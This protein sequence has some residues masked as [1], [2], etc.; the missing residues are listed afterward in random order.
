MGPLV[1]VLVADEL[2]AALPQVLVLGK[3]FDV[4]RRGSGQGDDRT[5]LGIPDGLLPHDAAAE[6]IRTGMIVLRVPPVGHVDPGVLPGVAVVVGILAAHE[7]VDESLADARGEVVED[8]DAAR[9]ADHG[10]AEVAVGPQSLG[11]RDGPGPGPGHPVVL[12]A[13]VHHPVVVSPF[14]GGQGPDGQQVSSGSDLDQHVVAGLGGV[15]GLLGQVEHPVGLGPL[16]VGG[17]ADRFAG[18]GLVR[19]SRRGPARRHAGRQP[20]GHGKALQKLSSIHGTPWSVVSG[21]PSRR[22]TR[23]GGSYRMKPGRFQ[24]SD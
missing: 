21:Q 20:R 10:P 4:S 11:G 9:L 19:R 24:A 17:V 23:R 22:P 13:G 3:R 1:D 6:H 15:G 14:P 2:T 7:G 18:S 16:P 12:A 8:V 5:V